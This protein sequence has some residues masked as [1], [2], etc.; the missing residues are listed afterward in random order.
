MSMVLEDI[1]QVS[2]AGQKPI[3]LRP[4]LVWKASAPIVVDPD[5]P[6]ARLTYVKLVKGR[7]EINRLLGQPFLSKGKDKRKLQH[8][9]IIESLVQLRNDR[10]NSLVAESKTKEQKIDLDIDESEKVGRDRKRSCQKEAWDAAALPEIV[11]IDCPAAGDTE[12][13]KMKVRV[14]QPYSPPYVELTQKSI[15]YLVAVIKHQ[16]DSGEIH[17]KH[18]R[19]SVDAD[20]KVDPPT[21]FSYSYA[22]QRLVKTNRV[23]SPGK[24]QLKIKTSYRRAASSSAGIDDLNTDDCVAGD[25]VSP[26]S[27]VDRLASPSKEDESSSDLVE[28]AE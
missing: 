20:A 1:V 9:S 24:Q 6:S 15:D 16:V 28:Q 13:I 19:Y 17:R 3:N 25:R 21:G 12:S 4:D 23:F 8:T 5:Q 18:K 27:P 10:I 11:E 14:D 26:A 2:I 22:R 7:S